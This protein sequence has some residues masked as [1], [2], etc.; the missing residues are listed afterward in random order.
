MS[1]WAGMVV[2][3]DGDLVP[4]PGGRRVRWYYVVAAALLAWAL[5]VWLWQRWRLTR[6]AT[7]G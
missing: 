1:A 2:M 3:G 7:I 6:T 4:D 5:G